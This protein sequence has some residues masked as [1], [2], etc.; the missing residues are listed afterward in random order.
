MSLQQLLTRFHG[1]ILED[2]ASVIAPELRDNGRLSPAAQMAIYIEGYRLRL[3]LALRSDYPELLA[4]LREEEFDALAS[5]YVEVNPPQHVSLDY[6]TFG[7]ADFVRAQK[8]AGFAADLAALEGAIA[9]VFLLPDSAA[10]TLEALSALA[11]E[12]L[13]A[14]APEAFGAARLRLREAAVLLSLDYPVEDY[15]ALARKGASPALPVPGPCAVL[16]VRHENEVRRH[17]L[18]PVAFALVSALA[19]GLC[20]GDA[21][22]RAS[23]SQPDALPILAEFLQPWFAQ[24]TAHGFFQPVTE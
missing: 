20:V 22:E 5:A 6:Y 9:R 16:V 21:L 23:A 2:D 15:F 19:E 10:L 7:F 24:W 12:A 17:V 3:V 11:P 1:A 8:G 14:L 13:S 4:H 18:A